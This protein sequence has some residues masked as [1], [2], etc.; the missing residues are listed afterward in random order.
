VALR[1]TSVIFG[2]LI[3]TL[4]L[5]EAFGLRRITASTLVLYGIAVLALNRLAD[6]N[7]DESP[8]SRCVCP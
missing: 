4:V 5:K 7:I 1:E 3:G 6:G 8:A 2:S